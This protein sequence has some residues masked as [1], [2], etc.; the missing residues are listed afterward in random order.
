MT[1]RNVPLPRM[2]E[3]GQERDGN[4]AADYLPVITGDERTRHRHRHRDLPIATWAHTDDPELL[5][6]VVVDECR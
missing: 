4:V 5:R 3:L 1:L 6:V 2:R